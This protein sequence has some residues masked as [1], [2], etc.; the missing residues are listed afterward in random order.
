MTRATARPVL[1]AGEQR[2]FAVE[3]ADAFDPAPEPWSARQI[4]RRLDATAAGWRSWS[5]LH[6][7]YEGPLRALVRRS[8]VVLQG[9]THARTGAVVAAATTSLPEG[10]GSSRTWDYRFTWVRDASMTLQGLWVA[11]CPDE[12]ERFFAFLTRA[13]MAPPGRDLELRP[14]I[15]PGG[16]HDLS[17]RELAHLAGWRGSAPVRVGNAAWRQTQLDVYGAV[18]DAAYTLRDQLGNLEPTTRSFLTAAVDT[19]AERWTE[20]DHGLWEDRGEPRPFVYSKLMC[21]VAM[22][23]G[24]RLAERGLVDA[25]RVGQW[26]AVRDEIAAAIVDQGWSQRAG[27]YAQ[28]FGSD[29]LDASLLRMAGLGFLPP[30]DPR[31]LATIDAIAA[32]LGDGRGLVRRNRDDADEDPPEGSFL[33]C[34]FWLAEA[35]AVTGQVERAREV[36]DRAA[37]YATDLGLLAEEVDPA[38]GEL[39]GNF[40]QAFS[41]LGLVV[42]A[43]ALAEA[44]ERSL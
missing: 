27:A 4:R 13:A 38:T 11:A 3:V 28:S 1:H 12:A 43:Q 10:V 32:G 29:A 17:E 41:H 21:W 7:A 16:E 9:L 6:Q 15:A 2:S 44:E 24:V 22:D 34:T 14:V 36:L 23:R 33:L 39:L 26:S 31:L 25:D 30:D 20:D 5:E 37:G 19:A 18:V 42:A 40:P 8:G 35:L